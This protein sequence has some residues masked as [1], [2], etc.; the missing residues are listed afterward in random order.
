MCRYGMC[1]QKSGA[2]H[3]SA[4]PESGCFSLS[5]S[6]R[7]VSDEAFCFSAKVGEQSFLYDEISSF[8]C[9]GMN[10]YLLRVLSSERLLRIAKFV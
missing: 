4:A 9:L 1:E 3:A 5:E 10:D 7:A 8:L 2:I 6:A